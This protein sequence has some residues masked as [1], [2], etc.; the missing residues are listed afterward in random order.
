MALQDKRKRA[1]EDSNKLRRLF[2]C[3]DNYNSPFPFDIYRYAT[4]LV[5][6][7]LKFEQKFEFNGDLVSL[8]KAGAT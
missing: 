2:L 8:M 5:S 3:Y 1:S 4:F 6:V 7:R